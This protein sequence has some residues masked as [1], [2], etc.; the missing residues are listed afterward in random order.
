MTPIQH[1]I[2]TEYAVGPVHCYSAEIAGEL[3]LF[4]TGPPTEEAKRYLQKNVDL[5]RLKHVIITHC[6]IDHY[7][8]VRWLE[9]ETTATIYLPF[10]DH[11][12]IIRHAERL[13]LMYDLMLQIGF[14]AAFLERFRVNM[15]DGTV[16]PPL[17][18]NFQIIEK[19]L[20]AQ[21][22]LTTLPCPGHSQS[23]MVL[24]GTD[25]AITGDV[26]LQGIFQTPLF[27][28]DLLTGERFCNYA[29]YCE[30]L[31]KLVTLRDKQILP[32]HRQTIDSVDSCL[33]FYVDKLLERA[34]RISK[35]PLDMTVAEIVTKLF[36]DDSKHPF[37]SY[38]KASEI[39][40]LRDFLAEPEL[41]RKV[42]IDIDLFSPVADKFSRAIA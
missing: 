16:F 9:R 17:P 37:I 1:T 13:E 12:K 33:L 21:L 31:V 7:G 14:E 42:L 25:W 11:L 2:N 28:V 3:I 23:D 26:M 27:D 38:L 30:S 10:R 4:D 41:L 36:K 40:F 34:A 24:I 6:H 18:E 5:E 15:E 32:G 20:P 39:V 8:L 35:L 22:G 29:A 19:S